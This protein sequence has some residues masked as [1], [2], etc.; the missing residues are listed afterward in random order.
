VYFPDYF[1]VLIILRGEGWAVGGLASE[2]LW[3]LDGVRKRYA[4][5]RSSGGYGVTAHEMGHGLGMYHSFGR[6]AGYG[7]EWDVMSSYGLCTSRDPEFGCLPVHPIAFHKEWVGWI[8]PERIVEVNAGGSTMV[9]LRFLDELPEGEGH[10]MIRVPASNERLY[11]VEARRRERRDTNVPGRAVLIHRVERELLAD[12]TVRPIVTIV[13]AE[14]QQLSNF[15]S[16][17]W[18]PGEIFSDP[19]YGIT[20][21]IEADLGDAFQVRVDRAP[22]SARTLAV[23][24]EAG[25]GVVSDPPGIDC[26]AGTPGG[27]QDCQAVFPYATEVRLTATGDPASPASHFRGWAGPCQL[28]GPACRVTLY[29]DESVAV[30]FG[31]E[32]LVTV[33]IIGRGV[34]SVTST[35]AGIDCGSRGGPSCSASFPVYS[36]VTLTAVPEPDSYF[37]AWDPRLCESNYTR[38]CSFRV[39]GDSLIGVR[40]EDAPIAPPV[41]AISPVNSSFIAMSGMSDPAD[42]ILRVSDL[43]GVALSDLAIGPIEYGGPESGWLAAGLVSSAAP[44]ELTLTLATRNL[45]PGKYIAGLSIT[46][47]AVPLQSGTPVR[48]GFAIVDLAVAE[49]VTPEEVVGVLL[50]GWT[51]HSNSVRYLDGTGNGDGQL[52]LADMLA[53]LDR[54][55]ESATGSVAAGEE[56]TP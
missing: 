40:F 7:S 23:S 5:A 31:A 25:G 28:D 22:L 52:D 18:L 42:R 3:E 8:P 38:T 41:L 26:G 44:T 2:P 16:E 6:G 24:A 51:V 4:Q 32:P 10:L 35:P 30:S 43:S 33:G 37:E 50:N 17:M 45:P 9:N 11:T 34:G 20:I 12:G 14:G 39:L 21:A 46:S 55:G 53:W 49:R 48:V 36:Q 54:E 29:D 19:D 13:E 27:G 47:T 1:G 56:D 15:E